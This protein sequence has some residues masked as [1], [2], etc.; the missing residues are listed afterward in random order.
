MWVFNKKE[1]QIHIQNKL[2][3]QKGWEIQIPSYEHKENGACGTEVRHRS[4]RDFL[5]HSIQ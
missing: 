3:Q 1:M 5:C 2:E 4:Q